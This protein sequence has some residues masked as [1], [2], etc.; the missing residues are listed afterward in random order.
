MP[1]APAAPAITKGSGAAA[2]AAAAAAA[3]AAPTG[4]GDDH[5]H[6]HNHDHAARP[7][8]DQEPWLLFNGT[9][10]LKTMKYSYTTL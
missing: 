1:A 8:K 6:G 4:H 10:V 7:E 5:G 2:P 9:Q 3:A